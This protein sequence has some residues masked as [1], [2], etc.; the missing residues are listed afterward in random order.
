MMAE[1]TAMND[2]WQILALDASTATEKDVKT[3][4]ARLLKQHRPDADPEGFQRVRQ[5]FEAALAALKGTATPADPQD[6]RAPLDYVVTPAA[7][8]HAPATPSHAPVAAPAEPEI[9]QA[10]ARIR[11]AATTRI[12]QKVREALAAFDEMAA[13]RGLPHT[14]Q[15]L[16]LGAAFSAAPNLLAELCGVDRLVRHMEAGDTSLPHAVLRLWSNDG[17]TKRLQEV[18]HVLLKRGNLAATELGATVLVHVAVALGAWEPAIAEE[19]SRKAFP[20][21]AAAERT[22]LTA[23]ADHEILLGRVFTG[24]PKD[25]KRFWL[26]FVRG[27]GVRTNWRDSWSRELLTFLLRNCSPKWPGYALLQ[28]TMPPEVW[29]DMTRAMRM[30]TG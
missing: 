28:R 2:A 21:L 1:P 13:Q 11:E 23:T 15:A 20:H 24:F 7:P 5:A 10:A 6:Q 4:Y 16:T 17:D 27:A 14:E 22:E 30:L 12:R 19:L 18:A 9:A 8:S 29:D 26:G 25:H 3:A